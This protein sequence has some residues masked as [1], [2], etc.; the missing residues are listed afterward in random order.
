MFTH[1]SMA[2]SLLPVLHTFLKNTTIKWDLDEI[3]IYIY[4]YIS[5]DDIHIHT[6]IHI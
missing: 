2:D 3:Y 5:S 4:I 1:P 6:H